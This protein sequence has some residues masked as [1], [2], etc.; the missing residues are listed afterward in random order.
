VATVEALEFHPIANVFPLLEGEAFGSLVAAIRKHGLL[1]P[2]T[3]YEG[4]ILDG[5]NRYNACMEAGVAVR[6]HEWQGESGTPAE[7]VWDKNAERRQLSTSQQA[8]AAVELLPHLEAE[9]KERREATQGRPRKLVPTPEPVFEQRESHTGRSVKHASRITGVGKTTISEAKRISEMAKTDPQA[10]EL[11]KQVKAGTISVHRAYMTLT[12]EGGKRGRKPTTAAPAPDN[13]PAPTAEDEYAA[14]LRRRRSPVAL[15]ATAPRADA[16]DASKSIY[17]SRPVRVFGV[18]LTG[19]R[20]DM[21]GQGLTITQ[22]ALE[23]W[24]DE[25]EA[26]EWEEMQA[27]VAW[28]EQAWE[29]LHK[30]VRR[31]L[32]RGSVPRMVERIERS[33]RRRA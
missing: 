24:W 23:A 8:M 9:A 4:K 18:S 17:A 5:R 14:A 31:K 20:L 19:T 2:I 3:L 16:G 13:T 28:F 32:N 15:V 27:S 29:P 33:Q 11:A 12:G 30:F 21:A 10:A 7:Y 22:E 26:R 6:S 25:V 1:D